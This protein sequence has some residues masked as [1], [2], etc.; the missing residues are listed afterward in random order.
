[1][2][3]GAGEGSKASYIEHIGLF[4]FFV[5]CAG[6]S[7]I[8]W[9]FNWICWINQCCCCDFLHNPINKRLVWWVCFIFLLGI[10]A[11]CISGFVTTNRFGF[12]LEGTWCAFD[13]F[14]YDS[15]YGQLK[16]TYPK[17]EGFDSIINILSDLSKYIDRIDEIDENYLI[18][19][20]NKNI[21][22]NKTNITNYNYDGYFSGEYLYRINNLIGDDFVFNEINP[23]T[24]PIALKYG[25]IVDASRKLREMKDKHFK[26]NLETVRNSITNIKN[27][28]KT[29]EQELLNDFHYYAKIAKGWGK[30]LTMIYFCLLCITITL[31]GFSM[32][33]YACLRR[34]GYLSIFMH[35]LWNIVRFFMFSYFF[36][37]AAYGMCYLGFKDAIAYIMFIFGEL[38]YNNI[39]NLDPN[40]QSYLIPKKEGK[41]FLHFCL[42]ENDNNYKNKLDQTL[43]TALEDY[44]KSYSEL[45]ET[46]QKTNSELYIQTNGNTSLD[47][48]RTA[49]M[50]MIDFMKGKI[51]QLSDDENCRKFGSI[52]IRNDGLF[53][54]FDCSFLKSHLNMIYRTLYDLSIESRIL[55][56]LSCCIAFF[57][58][59]FVYFFLLVLHHYNTDLFY[60]TGKSIFTGFEGYRN[61][62]NRDNKDPAYKKRK[63]RAEIE[64]SSRN[65][66]YSGY[67]PANK[68]EE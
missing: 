7:I 22:L 10:L 58:A 33:F 46:F 40:Q 30:I 24:L 39:N 68:N 56:A 27:D 4:F 60:D 16:E 21:V 1:M 26:D 12:A 41:E 44:F 37:G 17:W 45:N 38:D 47:N 61:T 19:D 2:L 67:Q 64:L 52:A 15:L 50:K 28:F 29:L 53:G 34:Q 43:L 13:R 23:K 55:C 63:I 6:V 48:I 8:V 57:G 11:C 66:E 49:H 59:I 18:L 3:I 25:R 62:R 51:V 9:V 65:E 54:S 35:V 31:A 20:D 32:M 42:I 5:A 36:Y 14:Y